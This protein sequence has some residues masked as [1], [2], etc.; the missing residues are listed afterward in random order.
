MGGK[1]VKGRKERYV[2]MYDK[3]FGSYDQL[4]YEKFFKNICR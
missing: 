3:I 4:T 1:K 2:A